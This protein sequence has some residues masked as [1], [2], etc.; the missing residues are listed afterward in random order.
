MSSDLHALN[1][2]D[3]RKAL[4]RACDTAGG[5]SAWG[6]KHGISQSSVNQT[7]SGVREPSENIINALGYS[8]VIRYVRMVRSA[9]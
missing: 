1:S 5:Q 6:R 8:R 9:A 7:L 3:L 2:A 4:L